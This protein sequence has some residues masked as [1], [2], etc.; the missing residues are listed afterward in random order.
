MH[1]CHSSKSYS[2]QVEKMQLVFVYPF[3]YG[4]MS[5][6]KYQYLYQNLLNILRTPRRSE[7][8]VQ[9]DW[10]RDGL[11]EITCDKNISDI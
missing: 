10:I 11:A 9:A 4:C 6:L 8:S 1:L 3:L 5:N 7:M 2:M